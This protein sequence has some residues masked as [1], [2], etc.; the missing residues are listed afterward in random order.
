MEDAVE[1]NHKS[2]LHSCS[3]G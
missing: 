3:N 1:R 2:S